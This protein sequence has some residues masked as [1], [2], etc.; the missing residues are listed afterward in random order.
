MPT[1]LVT[2]AAGFIGSR[3]VKSCSER[4]ISLLSVDH[5]EHFKTRHLKQTLNYGQK[6]DLESLIS[7]LNQN[8]PQLDAIAHLGAITDTRE[9]DLSLLRRLNLEY[10]QS[11]WEYATLH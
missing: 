4:Q 9:T 1:F 8:S 11:L 5:E 7:W 3:L 6:I 10:S 2:G